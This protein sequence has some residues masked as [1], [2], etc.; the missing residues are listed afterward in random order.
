MLER[1][2]KQNTVVEVA[3]GIG[4]FLRAL[5]GAGREAVGID[6]VFSKLWLAKRYLG[7]RGELICGDIE[8]GPIVETVGPTTVFCHDA[9][10]FFEHKSR[11]LDNMRTI[12]SGGCVAVGHVHTKRSEHE[13]G[14]ALD[15]QQY[16]ELTD[17]FVRDDGDFVSGWYDEHLPATQ[18]R[19]AAVAW[20]EGE[21]ERR[22]IPWLQLA[23]KL[24]ENPLLAGTTVQWPS[25][26]WARE[27]GE[28]SRCLNGHSITS[29]IG[30]PAPTDRFEQF[31][32]RRLI[33]L[34]E[35]W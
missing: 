13:A 7:V 25:D 15:K 8:A 27:Y 1:T 3:C 18:D 35:Q 12:S 4:H 9:F 5:E 23:V 34:P 26:G 19:T 28:D 14:F 31:R 22:E 17:A 29:L 32:Q 11:A 33:N 21:T 10:Y 24:T 2:P 6:I 16:T 20:I 30:E